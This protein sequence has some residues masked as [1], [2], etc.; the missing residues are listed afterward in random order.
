MHAVQRPEVLDDRNGE[1]R[2]RVER[3]H[4][5]RGDH[6]RQG[7]GHAD[8][9]RA[10]G[11]IDPYL[12]QSARCAQSGDRC[13]SGPANV[14]DVR[15]EPGH[16]ARS[17]APDRGRR[18]NDTVLGDGATGSHVSNPRSGGCNR[19]GH[20]ATPRASLPNEWLVKQGANT[21]EFVYG[22]IRRLEQSAEQA[23]IHSH[24][25]RREDECVEIPKP[26]NRGS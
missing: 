25:E 7:E 24:R 14:R 16:V 23:E 10:A 17:P 1:R 3:R 13:G 20:A 4:S 6:S 21:T 15:A 12:G 11:A 26:P 5:R 18:G 22:K 8:A 19:N 2:A 9:G